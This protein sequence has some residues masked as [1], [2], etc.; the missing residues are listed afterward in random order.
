MAYCDNSKDVTKWGSEEVAIEY[1][2]PKDG[3]PHRYFPDFI[4]LA[5][6]QKVLVEIKPYSMSVKPKKESGMVMV[7]YAVNMAKWEAAKKL[8]DAQGFKFAVLTE[9]E[10]GIKKRK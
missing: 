2:S 1:I 9:Y 7:Q 5:G 4:M 10:L 6:G 8:C 3:K